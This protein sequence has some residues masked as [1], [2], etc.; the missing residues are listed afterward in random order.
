M[1]EKLS[2][3]ETRTDVRSPD[4][5]NFGLDRSMNL[6]YKFTNNLSSK[7]SWSGQSK[8]NDFRGYAWTSLRDLDPGTVTQ[9]TESFNTTFNPGLMKWLKPSFNYTANFRWTDDLAREGQ[10]ISTQLRFGSN[11]SLTPVQLIELIY[12]PK[13]TQKG[14]T[15]SRS[16]GSRSRT[17]EK[18]KEKKNKEIGGQDISAHWKVTSCAFVGGNVKG[19]A[20]Y[21]TVGKDTLMAVPIL[22]D[23]SMDPNYDPH[24]GKLKK[25]CQ[26]HEKSFIPNH[27]D[28]YA[29]ALYLSG[30]DSKGRGRNDR[31]PLKFI[32]KTS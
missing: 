9:T 28:V 15:G 16:R 17:Q 8:L 14:R 22:P 32:K 10:N 13:S 1:N 30:L 2:W 21:G 26:K 5:N 27:G 3:N 25:D 29:T 19:D 7:Y 4:N 20:Q 23:G 6:D 24:T 18:S 12:K 11:F 31:P